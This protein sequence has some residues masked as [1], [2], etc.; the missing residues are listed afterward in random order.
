MH[1][2]NMDANPGAVCGVM[3]V[4]LC[5]EHVWQ[6]IASAKGVPI[7]DLLGIAPAPTLKNPSLLHFLLV[8]KFNSDKLFF[9][10]QVGTHP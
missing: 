3:Y 4:I 5:F 6:A 2:F 10:W 7:S 1:L 8:E 9:D